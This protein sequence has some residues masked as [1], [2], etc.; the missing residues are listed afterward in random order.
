MQR[1]ELARRIYRTARISGQFILRSGKTTEHYFDKY[2]F[3]SDPGLL[4]AIAAAMVPLVPSS[5]E[6]LAGLAI[7]GIPVA[8]MLSQVT[9]LPTVFV[10][11]KALKHG[12]SKLAEGPDVKGRR[13]VI[14]EDVVTTA[15]QTVT[16]AKDLRSLGAVVS[17]VVCVIDREAGGRENLEKE[18]LILRPLFTISDLR[19][20]ASTS[21]RP[22]P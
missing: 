19:Q 1:N 5:G 8:V 9:G 21:P 22:S 12:T 17:D 6:A 13:L 2:L 11:K 14:V 15:G 7:G 4:K 16:C 20:A 3:E 18:G 10:R